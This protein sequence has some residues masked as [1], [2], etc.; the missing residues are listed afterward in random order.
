[1]VKSSLSRVNLFKKSLCL[2]MWGIK[3]LVKTAVTKYCKYKHTGSC[4]TNKGIETPEFKCFHLRFV[5][6][7]L[8]FRWYSLMLKLS[9]R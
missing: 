5:T 9:K 2:V 3:E 8:L 7:C 4:F 1:M 6:R